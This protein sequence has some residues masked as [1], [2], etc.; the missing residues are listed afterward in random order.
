[1]MQPARQT[2]AIA[3]MFNFQPNCCATVRISWNPCAYETNLAA[4]SAYSVVNTTSEL[5]QHFSGEDTQERTGCHQNS[6]RI[7][8]Y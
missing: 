7:K 6:K 4:Y 1:M 8:V 2:I 5:R 3:P